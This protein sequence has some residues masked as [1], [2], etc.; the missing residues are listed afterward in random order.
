MT[1]FKFTESEKPPIVATLPYQPKE[2]EPVVPVVEKL[3]VPEP[4]AAVVEK[5]VSPV[6]APVSSSPSISSSTPA[7]PEFPPGYVELIQKAQQYEKLLTQVV[8]LTAEVD[9]L[10]EVN[11]QLLNKNTDMASKIRTLQNQLPKSDPSKPATLDEKDKVELFEKED[12]KQYSNI[13][14]WHVIVIALICLIIGRIL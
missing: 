13:Q 6:V 10:S 2:A 9:R 4:K 14:L 8:K 12:D 1:S 5:T 11:K 3:N 7:I